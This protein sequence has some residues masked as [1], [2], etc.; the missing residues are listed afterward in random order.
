MLTSLR[1]LVAGKPLAAHRELK[2]LFGRLHRDEGGNVIVLFMA[3]ALLLVGMVWAVVGTGSRL[4]QKET[5]QSSADA[6][7]YS[8][9]VIKAKGLNIIAFC[10]LVMALLL[11]IIMLLRMIELTLWAIAAFAVVACALTG[12]ACGVAG[13]AAQLANRYSD[14]FNRIEPRI[15]DAMKVLARVERVVNTT[16]PALSLVEAYQVGTNEA[17]RKHMGAGELV[18]VTWPLPV[19][20][21]LKL[22]TKDGTWDKLCDEATNTVERL[23]L[24]V[25][26]KIGIP[27]TVG[28]FMGRFIGGFIR[29][30]SSFL[31]GG[32]GGSSTLM[33][34]HAEERFSCNQCGGAEGMVFTGTRII[35]KPNGQFDQFIPNQTCTVEGARLSYCANI[36][37]QSRPCKEGEFKLLQFQKCVVK[38]QR[39][40]DLGQ[41]VSNDDIKPL[42]LADDFATRKFVRGFSV[43]TDTS[44]EQRRRSVAVAAKGQ[45]GGNPGA[46]QLLSMAQAEMYAHNGHEDLWHM[47]WRSRLVRFTFGAGMAGGDQGDTQGK[48]PSGAADKILGALNS[49]TGGAARGLADQFLLH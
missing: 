33:I 42:E 25:L 26:D 3:T 24:T 43:L 7:A 23:V 44:M 27:S 47:N 6:A 38:T 40:A 31:C 46:N 9:A 41:P 28:R 36:G 13:P 18:A 8:A 2:S 22:P 5:I 45:G 10:N 37:Q 34:D 4:V 20:A 30:V 39:P 29:P 12:V 1:R 15:K 35:R 48:V 11:A 49:F 21:D 32:G 14:L 19:G 17:Y 16:F